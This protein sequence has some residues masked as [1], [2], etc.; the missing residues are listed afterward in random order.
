MALFIASFHEDPPPG[1]LEKASKSFQSVYPLSS[2][3]WI[4]RAN[5][6]S[7]DMLSDF[8]G[9]DVSTHP[10]T[11]GMVF[12]LNGSYSGYHYERLWDWLEEARERIYG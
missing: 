3:T 12:K 6:D 4:I 9:M 8:L 11:I 2:N 1:L 5:A 7:T 10:R